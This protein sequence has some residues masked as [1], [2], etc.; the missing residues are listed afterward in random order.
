MLVQTTREQRLRINDDIS[1]GRIGLE[2]CQSSTVSDTMAASMAALLA[3]EV[4]L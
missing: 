3:G 1:P 2:S 4:D